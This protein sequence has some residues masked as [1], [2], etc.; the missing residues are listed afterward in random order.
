MGKIVTPETYWVGT[1][2]LDMPGVTAYLEASGNT[3]FLAT[4]KAA[5]EQGVSDGEVLCSMMAKICYA[6]LT[7]GH[8]DN[9]TRT[10]DIP[11]NVRACFDQGHGSVFEHCWLNFVTRNCSRVLTHELVRHRIGTAF[12][13]TSGRYVRSD[14][15]DV[16]TDPVL[17]EHGV[18]TDGE[19]L[20]VQSWLERLMLKMSGR[21]QALAD[22]GKADMTM[23]KKLTS[24]ARRWMPNG[25]A[26]EIGFSLNLRSL[27]HVVMM[28]TSRGAEREIRLVFGQVYRLV[29]E[30]YPLAF[31]G[32]REETVDGLVEVTGMKTQP[33]EQTEAR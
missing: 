7:L 13:Q 31:H 1:T 12:S 11:D 21:I 3:D 22:A 27:R 19:Q 14:R 29:K 33:Y 20:E 24:A 23:K 16:V 9:L 18:L 10:R 4:I 15:L 30:K 28:R 2:V 5:K 25:Q 32:A 26:N 17:A 8:N 6:A